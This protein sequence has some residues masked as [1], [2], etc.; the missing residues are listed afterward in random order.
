MTRKRFG[1]GDQSV[2]NQFGKGIFLSAPTI[3]FLPVLFLLSFFKLLCCRNCIQLCQNIAFFPPYWNSYSLL[4]TTSTAV[5]SQSHCFSAFSSPSRH[6]SLHLAATFIVSSPLHN[7]RSA[8]LVVASL[9]GPYQR[10]LLKELLRDYNPM[11]RPVANDSQALTVQFSFT[12]M[13]VMDV[14]RKAESAT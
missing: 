14:V 2:R 4:L 8:S 7:S 1:A 6:S 5:S 11:E 9:Q 3:S 13:Q 10:V 12:L